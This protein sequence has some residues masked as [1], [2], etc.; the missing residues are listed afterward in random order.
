MDIKPVTFER[1]ILNLAYTQHKEIEELTKDL[2]KSGWDHW[3]GKRKWRSV[4]FSLQD[5]YDKFK[6]THISVDIAVE[7][8]KMWWREKDCLYKQGPLIVSNPE[9][10]IS[11]IKSKGV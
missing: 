8:I 5:E 2:K 6:K 3:E 4:C 7:I 1:G 10:L 11:K 9:E